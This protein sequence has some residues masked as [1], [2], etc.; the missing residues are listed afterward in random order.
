[1]VGG[2]GSL[3]A[4]SP[5][6]LRTVAEHMAQA[7]KECIWVLLCDGI[8]PE[9]IRRRLARGDAGLDYK[10]DPAKRTFYDN[11][12]RLK[13]ERGEPAP[14]IKP[15][16]EIEAADA[17]RRAGIALQNR[18]LARLKLKDEAGTFTARDQ[19]ELD[20]ILRSTEEM[21]RRAKKTKDPKQGGKQVR[22]ARDIAPTSLLTS[23]GREL[24][25]NEQ[26]HQAEGE[27]QTTQQGT[28]ITT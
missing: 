6:I 7:T 8:G 27:G 18:R 3:D 15:G 1:M 21:Q 12:A 20:V 17:I 14:V 9:E 28:S 5:P 13:E 11:V 4:C 24:K 23:L 10:T 22:T 2:H 25:R 16:E 26:R 19:R